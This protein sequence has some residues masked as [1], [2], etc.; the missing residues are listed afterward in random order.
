MGWAGLKV[1]VYIHVHVVNP[2]QLGPNPEILNST[3]A[4]SEAYVHVCAH[5][6]VWLNDS[7]VQ[8][9]GDSKRKNNSNLYVCTARLRGENEV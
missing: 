9:F 5:V 2:T 8:S 4:H 3:R 6:H 7:S 1:H